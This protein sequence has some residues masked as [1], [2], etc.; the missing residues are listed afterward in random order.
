M[1]K[2]CCRCTLKKPIE[3]FN[4]KVKSKNKKKS[5]CRACDRLGHKKFY[6]ANTTR[7]KSESILR[8]KAIRLK[9]Q[10][11]KKTL[12]CTICSES[13]SVCLDFH[14]T[15]PKHKDDSIAALVTKGVS[16]DKLMKEV[17]KCIVVCRNCHT[18]IHAY[19][20]D[21]VKKDHVK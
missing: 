13:D 8:G 16:W 9:F 11:F 18:K 6:Q 19:G 21:K 14:H 2:V 17:D 5:Y 1:N 20:I 4:W 12:S 10:Q 7:L 3:D 15:D